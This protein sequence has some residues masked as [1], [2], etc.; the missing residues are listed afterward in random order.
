MRKKKEKKMHGIK[1][2][3]DIASE[4]KLVKKVRHKTMMK[5]MNARWI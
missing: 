1:L 2:C 4:S 5:S 3:I